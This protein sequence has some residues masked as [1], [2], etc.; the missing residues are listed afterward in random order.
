MSKRLDLTG[1]R[2]GKLLA[3]SPSENSVSE[4]GR[5]RSQWLCR[6]DCG[7]ECLVKTDHLRAGLTRSC[8]C[9]AKENNANRTHGLTGTRIYVE[10]TSMKSRCYNV[11]NSAYGRYG[12]RGIKVCEEWA[13]SFENFYRWATENGYNDSLTIERKNV[14]GDYSPENC[15]WITKKEQA[16][17]RR[18]S[19]RVVSEDGTE[20]LAMDVASR[21][22]I[23]MSV[24]RARVY[25]GWSLEEAL[26]TPLIQQTVKRPVEQISLNDGSVISIYKSI[27]DASCATGIERSSISR[28][29]SGERNKAGGYAWRYA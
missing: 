13:N 2:F 21:N 7:N 12:G 19:I 29:C 1:Q 10:W 15:C 9:Y 5:K 27:G 6:C 18:K 8:G 25:K 3:I 4:N 17:N 28:C 14:D 11:K 20:E 16:R 26:K 23:D 24:V 22:G